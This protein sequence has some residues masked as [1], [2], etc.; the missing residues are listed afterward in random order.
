M[1]TSTFRNISVNFATYSDGV[2]DECVYGSES[3]KIPFTRE[4]LTK[5]QRAV[6]GLEYRFLID[7]GR[8]N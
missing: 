4:C 8:N 7:T 5:A 3:L 6:A 2:A 1:S